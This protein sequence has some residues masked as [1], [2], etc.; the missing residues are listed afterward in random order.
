MVSIFAIMLGFFAILIPLAMT[1]AIIYV[2]ARRLGQGSPR[3]RAL[4]AR[5]PGPQLRPPSARRLS[6]AFFDGAGYKNVLMIA[7]LAEG[8]YL[9][10]VP[11]LGSRP[12][13]MLIPW[14]VVRQTD[15][16]PTFP[17]L[18]ADQWLAF[19]IDSVPICVPASYL[20]ALPA[21]PAPPAPL[22]PTHGAPG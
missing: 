6:Q 20:P 10:R 11:L 2:V 8:L 13:T 18:L 22:P 9:E 3:W 16:V 12:P 1:G 19:D 17:I 15:A 21:S 14:Q 7:P 4:A 5:Y